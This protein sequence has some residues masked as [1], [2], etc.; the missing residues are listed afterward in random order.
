[1]GKRGVAEVL[2]G[3]AMTPALAIL[4]LLA[5]SLFIVEARGVLGAACF[6]LFLFVTGTGLLVGGFLSGEL[7]ALGIRDL[8]SDGARNGMLSIA[9]RV[10]PAWLGLL[11][12]WPRFRARF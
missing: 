9:M 5:G 2:A 4:C 8:W 10:P 6:V 12:L 11:L 3:W 1:M 7:V